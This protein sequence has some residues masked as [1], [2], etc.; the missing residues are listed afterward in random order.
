M[1]I[2]S[3]KELDNFRNYGKLKLDFSSNINIFTGETVMARQ[4]CW[5][6]Y[7]W[8]QPAGRFGLSGMR[9]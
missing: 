9:K 7:C 4:I 5:K 2:D 6:G 3:L 1:R 8:R